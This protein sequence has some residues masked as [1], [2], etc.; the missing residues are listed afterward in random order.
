MT[1]GPRA[2]TSTGGLWLSPGG[3]RGHRGPAVVESTWLHTA[4]QGWEMFQCR[5]SFSPSFPPRPH[6]LGEETHPS[7]CP[8][9]FGAVLT[10]L[11]VLW[12]FSWVGCGGRGAPARRGTVSA[13]R[14]HRRPRRGSRAGIAMAMQITT[15]AARRRAG[16]AGSSCSAAAT[17]APARA[18][19][20]S[21]SC[22][23][24]CPS[25]VIPWTAVSTSLLRWSPWHP[26]HLRQSQRLH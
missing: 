25:P 16:R 8:Q 11:P 10:P 24:P 22:D 14:R 17:L 23:I 3:L 4:G 15:A 2:G 7:P 9:G 20:G 19:L 13:W 1:L 26:S 6:V 18:T 21:L 5:L 12:P